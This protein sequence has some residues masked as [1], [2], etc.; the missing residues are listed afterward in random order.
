MILGWFFVYLYKK[1]SINAK[2]NGNG[3]QAN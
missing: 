3:S 2:K 1:Y